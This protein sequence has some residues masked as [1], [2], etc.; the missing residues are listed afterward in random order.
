MCRHVHA[1]SLPISGLLIVLLL[2]LAVLGQSPE[3]MGVD[4][5]ELLPP[6]GEIPDSP[7]PLLAPEE[8]FVEPHPWYTT[9]LLWFKSP[10]WDIGAELGINGS[11]GNAQAFSL[12]TSFNGKRESD[13]HAFDWDLRYG[14]TQTAGI[15]T[16]HFALF[17][18]RWDWKYNPVWFFYLKNNL[19]YDEFKAF[20]I[21]YV[22]TAGLGH[23]VIKTEM[24]TLTG[25]LGAGT[26]REFGGPDDSWVPEANAGFD[27]EKQLSARQKL[28]LT[29]DYYPS[30]ED[31]QD[32]RL[33]TNAHWEI[34]LD[35]E[36]NL[37]LKVGAVNRYD[38][39]PNGLEPNDIDYFVTLL[40]KL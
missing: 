13:S 9:P 12:I 38:S 19:E 33:V 25:R 40:W 34:L 32:Y 5:L 22:A 37:S 6:V 10:V 7:D 29:S 14:K 2:Q 24:T 20:D 36:T 16:Q 18:S 26:S 28:K 1:R 31:F 8:V 39:T 21:R 30:W 23:H 15:E 4:E 27:F 35:E 3:S 17:N 11:E